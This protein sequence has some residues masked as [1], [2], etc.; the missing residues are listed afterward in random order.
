M[1]SGRRVVV[2]VDVK[3][4]VCH[5]KLLCHFLLLQGAPASQ[6]PPAPGKN[7]SVG[8]TEKRCLQK[9]GADSAIPGDS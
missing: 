8:T 4:V 3:H 6:L 5:E 1:V 7:S 9:K 2:V